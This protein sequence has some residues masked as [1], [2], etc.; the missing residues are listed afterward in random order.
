MS[1]TIQGYAVVFNSESED[2]GF[3]EII[4]PEAITEDTIKNSDVFA[5]FNHSDDRPLAR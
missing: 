3:I 5:L 2:M 4:H 1:R